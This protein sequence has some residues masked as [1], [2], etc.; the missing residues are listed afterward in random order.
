[1]KKIL[2]AVVAVVVVAMAGSAMALDTT[3]VAVSASVTGT[4]R[5][6][7]GGTVSFTLDPAVGGNV[8]GVV[9]Q[10]TFWCTN[11]TTYT[12]TDDNGGNYSGTSRRMQRGTS[13]EFIPYT[14]T[15]TGTGTGGGRNATRTMNIAS[16][17]AEAD[18]TG[19]TTGTYTDTVTLTITP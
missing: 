5:F 16:S 17:V 19:A 3:T 12:I 2:M 9:T 1:M 14:F 8:S 11:G 13:G 7:G 10:P 18:Y 6:L 15:Y 4:C